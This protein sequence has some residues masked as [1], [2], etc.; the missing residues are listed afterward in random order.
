M[1]MNTKKLL[2]ILLASFFLAACTEQSG[3]STAFSEDDDTPDDFEFAA[4]GNVDVAIMV[5]S[6]EITVEGIDVD[7][8]VTI[9]SGEYS[10]N[11]GAYTSSAGAVQAG[12]TLQ[13]RHLSS[14]DYNATVTS[15]LSVGSSSVNFLSTTKEQ[16]DQVADDTTPEA[17]SFTGE[18]D[19]A[20]ASIILSE[21]VTISGINVAASVSVSGGEYSIDGGAFTSA[22]GSISNNQSLQLRHTSSSS[23]S[24]TTITTITVGDYSTTFQSTTS[25]AADSI[26]DAF[27]FTTQN[28]VTINTVVESEAI[29]ISGFDTDASLSISNGEYSL[30]GGSNYSATATT[31]SPDST[32]QVRHTSS[33]EYETSMITT[34]TVGGVEGYFESVT[35]GVADDT[36]PNA[37]SFASRND[38]K[39]SEAML[40]DSVTISGINVAVPVS[41]SGGEYSIDGGAFTGASGSISNGQS[42]RLSHTSAATHSTTITTTV[43]I[44]DYSASF[45]STTIAESVDTTPDAFTFTTRTSVT[46]SSLI[47]SESIKITGLGAPASLSVS[48]GEYSVDGGATYSSADS[49]I[50]TGT[51]IQLR[52]A[53]SSEYGTSTV[54]TL[55]IG[56]VEGHF[57][58][59]TE[60]APGDTEPNAFSFATATDSATETV[61]ESAAVIISGI[62]EPVSVTVSNGEYA[63]DGGAYTAAEG[64]IADGQSLQLRHTTPSTYSTTTATT[65]TVGGISAEFSSTTEAEPLDT[66]PDAFAFTAITDTELGAKIESDPITVSGIGTSVGISVTGGEYK[67]NDGDYTA[68]TGSVE[69][70]D[71]VRVQHTSATTNSAATSTVLTIGNLSS[72]FTSTT[73]AEAASDDTPDAISFA[74]RTDVELA[75]LTESTV[76]T[77]SGIDIPAAVSIDYGEYRID[78]GAYTAAAGTIGNNQSLQIRHTSSS[79][80]DGEQVSTISV[81]TISA[82]FTTRTKAEPLDTEIDPISFDAQTDVATS[83]VYSS[84]QVNISGI[85]AD[86]SVSV[87][88]TNGEYRTDLSSDDAWTSAAG[89]LSLGDALQVRHTSAAAYSSTQ[90]TTITIE[91]EAFTFT[92]TTMAQPSDTEPDAFSF[93]AASDVDLSSEIVSAYVLVLDIDAPSAISVSGGSYQIYQDGSSEVY[94]SAA[95]QVVEGDRVRVKH[96]SAADYAATTTTTLTIGGVSAEFSSTTAARDEEPEAFSFAAQANTAVSSSISSEYITVE[97]INAPSAISVSGGE[98]QINSELYTAVAG[99]VSAGDQ[100]R[101]RHTSSSAYATTTTSTLTIGGISAQFSSTTEAADTT[102]DAF[103][104]TAQTDVGL[105]SILESNSISVSGINSPSAISVSGGSYSVNGS[106]HTS[107]AGAVSAGDQVR[108]SHTSSA[109]YGTSTTT[110]LTIG[111]V[112][113]QFSSTTEAADTTPDA[114]SFADQTDVALSTTVESTPITVSGINSPSAISVSGG[115]YSVNGASATDQDGAV[116]LDDEVR[117]Q[118]TSSSAYGGSIT[119]TLTI[120]GVSAEFSSTTILTEPFAVSGSVID[121]PLHNARVFLDMDDD[122]EWD[123]DEPYAFTDENGNYQLEAPEEYFDIYRLVAEITSETIDTETGLVAHP[124]SLVFYDPNTQSAFEGFLSTDYVLNPFTTMIQSEVEAGNAP[125]DAVELV[126]THLGLSPQY[127]F[128][129]LA[130][131]MEVKETGVYLDETLSAD[132]LDVVNRLHNIART[133]VRVLG[134]KMTEINEADPTLSARGKALASQQVLNALKI[135][136][137]DVINTDDDVATDGD[138]SDA[139]QELDLNAELYAANIDAD[140]ILANVASILDDEDS[141]KPGR[142]VVIAPDYPLDSSALADIALT[143]NMYY[144]EN[145]S[146]VYL[147]DVAND[148]IVVGPIALIADSPN[149]QSG[150]FSLSDSHFS[151]EAVYQLQVCLENASGISCSQGFSATVMHSEEFDSGVALTLPLAASGDPDLRP[152]APQWDGWMQNVADGY[153]RTGDYYAPSWNKWSGALAETYEFYRCDEILGLG[154]GFENSR[155]EKLNADDTAP[156]ALSTWDRWLGGEVV[157]Q[158]GGQTA[159]EIIAAAVCYNRN[160]SASAPCYY[161]EDGSDKGMQHLHQVRLCNNNYTDCSVSPVLKLKVVEDDGTYDVA[162]S[163]DGSGTEADQD[164][165]NENNTTDPTVPPNKDADPTIGDNGGGSVTDPDEMAQGMDI[166]APS[167]QYVEGSWQ[168]FLPGADLSIGMIKY[169]GQAGDLWELWAEGPLAVVDGAIERDASLAQQIASGEVSPMPAVSETWSNAASVSFAEEGMYVI[170]GAFCNSGNNLADNPEACAKSSNTQTIEVSSSTSRTVVSTPAPD[171]GGDDGGDGGSGDSG[172]SSDA[173]SFALLE[174]EEYAQLESERRGDK[175]NEA[176]TNIRTVG[177]DKHE[178]VDGEDDGPDLNTYSFANVERVQAIYVERYAVLEGKGLLYETA[179]DADNQARIAWEWLFP[180]ANGHIKQF[181]SAYNEDVANGKYPYTYTNYLKAVAKYPAFCGDAAADS[182][183]DLDELCMQAM[184]SMF[185]HFAQEVGGHLGATNATYR[186]PVND[187]LIDRSGDKETGNNDDGGPMKEFACSSNESGGWCGDYAQSI[188]EWRQALYWVNESG[189]SETGAGCLYRSCD[190]GTWQA[191]AW[192]C[193]ADTKYFGRGPKQLS[194]NYNYGPYSYII[195]GD[196]NPLLQNP[197]KVTEGWLAFASA[198]YFFMQPRPPKPSMF[199]LIYGYWTA[200]TV[201]SATEVDSKEPGPS[202]GASI[203]I[204][205]GGIECGGSKATAQAANRVKYYNGF[206]DYF[207]LDPE[208]GITYDKTGVQ[209]HKTA[210]MSCMNMLAFEPSHGAAYPSYWEEDWS[211]LGQCQ[212]VTYETA[213]SGYLDGDYEKCVHNLLK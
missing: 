55:T 140:A 8:N 132:D 143:W 107:N 99:T 97:G 180:M 60:A 112:S 195:Y 1:N 15:V 201:N 162:R 147:L 114:F 138:G 137:R 74:T 25:A 175:L 105:S 66:E 51:S 116:S 189:C 27:G 183:A 210:S 50:S 43:S 152:Q 181:P 126:A 139:E 63:I 30:D 188:P 190:P 82:S 200:P 23:N 22:T 178:V 67:V 102:P 83:T 131:Y 36:T 161:L 165:T 122:G 79:S 129:L 73:K 171:T 156:E 163:D 56:G 154:D 167:V 59:I 86:V 5:E 205:N 128:Y 203:M 212:L 136:L 193:P 65:V 169:W 146:S 32:I 47:E 127:H 9:K 164:Q 100:V 37:F 28:A 142:P 71:I 153:V 57:E 76:V 182:S 41:V 150:E 53:S 155:C 7:V 11:G 185:A 94:T 204:I 72:T 123:E 206:M 213:F 157:G 44:G 148:S 130:D 91:G 118:H 120:G 125:L 134:I 90:T 49:S 69:A 34:L 197:A 4:Q 141:L 93:A 62:S 184:A 16:A 101:V 20:L 144:G 98:Y 135:K 179:S 172:D 170:F 68:A 111:G 80:N 52:H 110:T 173:T 209:T 46:T 207:G 38:V 92:T 202:F 159:K 64:S 54:T 6:E 21:T 10:L 84:N 70:G 149:A 14:S 87:S 26:P 194:Y 18:N 31:L 115:S 199:E 75:T 2:A 113:A 3:L 198:V 42:L 133:A 81:G 95:G 109:A 48:N 108:V 176:I 39:L 168:P 24:I 158:A 192:P 45:H 85:G 19:V 187:T 145:G 89:S 61:V 77:I 104:F 96:T 33:S 58:S 78:G 196:V 13:V 177:V 29:T 35:A 186:A 191:E 124:Y 166:T 174:S 160:V 40:S 121:G 12:D 211:A 88:I 117:V 119:T 17:F 106:S 208:M 151:A 103:S